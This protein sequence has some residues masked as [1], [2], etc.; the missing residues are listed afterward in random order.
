MIRVPRFRSAQGCTVP[1]RGCYLVDDDFAQSARAWKATWGRF[2]WRR[3][4]TRP[5]LSRFLGQQGVVARHAGAG[6]A[7][8]D[9]PFQLRLFR[10]GSLGVGFSCQLERNAAAM[11]DAPCPSDR[12]TWKSGKSGARSTSAPTSLRRCQC[13][14]EVAEIVRQARRIWSRTAVLPRTCGMTDRASQF[15]TV[16][17][18]P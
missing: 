8:P 17:S 3:I 5:L 12:R 2:F 14:Q 7:S 16:V 1:R 4:Q 10:N 11:K 9:H 6:L 15:D 13:R 18:V